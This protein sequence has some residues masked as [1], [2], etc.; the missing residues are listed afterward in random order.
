MS[1]LAPDNPVVEEFLLALRQLQK[2]FTSNSEVTAQ[3]CWLRIVAWNFKEQQC[4]ESIR[5][6]CGKHIASEPKAY[7]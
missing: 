2:R 7:Q 1:A 6:H 3:L 5:R 4:L